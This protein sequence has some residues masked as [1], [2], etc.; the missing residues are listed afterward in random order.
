MKIIHFTTLDTGGAY[1]AVKRISDS[2]TSVGIDSRIYVRNALY[3]SDVNIVMNNSI[4]NLVSKAK[5]VINM[6][7]SEKG[8]VLDRFGYEISKYKNIDDA[9]I[10]VLH[11][12]NSFI[13]PREIERLLKTNKQII[14]VMHDMYPFTGGCHY[15]LECLEKDCSICNMVTMR[16][17]RDAVKRMLQMKIRIAHYPNMHY[18]AISS[19]EYDI[20]KT[21]LGLED[22]N[23]KL[24]TISNPLDVETFKPLDRDTL[25]YK[26]GLNNKKVIL[27][28]ADRITDRIKGIHYIAEVIS[29]I[30]DKNVVFV[31]FGAI[32]QDDLIQPNVIHLGQIKEEK[33]LVDWYNIADVYLTTPIQEAFGYTVCEAL[34]CGT[35]VVAHGVGGILDQVEH[36]KNGYLTDIGNIEEIIKGIIYCIQEGDTMRKQARVSSVQF[37]MQRIGKIWNEYAKYIKEH[38]YEEDN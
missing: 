15:S 37:C 30:K 9:D 17:N 8:L 5:N 11:W 24:I 12:I 26:K 10:I 13:S 27:F 7:L 21:R 31:C 19:W 2:M 35:P 16:K 22:D 23:S 33:E 18:V 28:G 32:E 4:K 34:G 36:K 3:Q 6:F 1:K 29:R 14:W 25:R 20:A 38:I